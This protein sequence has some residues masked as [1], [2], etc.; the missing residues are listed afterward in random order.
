MDLAIMATFTVAAI[1]VMSNLW[2]DLQSGYLFNAGRDQ[3]MW[4]WFFA[5]TAHALAQF[6]SPL[7]SD[8]QNYP[9]GVNLMANTAMFGISI[10]LAP[11]TLIFGPTATYAI[12]LTAGLGGTAIAWYW[13]FSRHVLTGVS[14]RSKI[15][16]AVGAGSADSR[17][18]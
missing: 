12:G 5:D 9:L 8:L 17:P 16:A 6:R 15:A 14:V 11:I 3:A 13:A 10:P 7:F 18:P 4:E 2:S 1:Y